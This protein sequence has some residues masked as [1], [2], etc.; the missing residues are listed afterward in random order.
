MRGAD[1]S[2]MDEKG[3][4]LLHLAVESRFPQIVILLLNLRKIA[5]I[6]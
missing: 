4:M 5:G 2:T 3:Q 6:V 1:M